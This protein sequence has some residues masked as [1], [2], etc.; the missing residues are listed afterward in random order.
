MTVTSQN[1][2]YSKCIQPSQPVEPVDS[3][4]VEVETYPLNLAVMSRRCRWIPR[5]MHLFLAGEA[6]CNIC[7]VVS[8]SFKVYASS[9]D[10]D[11]QVLG[12]FL[13]GEAL[14]LE[15]ATSQ[16]HMYS[17]VALEDAEVHEISLEKM[18]GKLDSAESHNRN[19]LLQ[20]LCF[21][22]IANNYMAMHG[23]STKFSEQR[24]SSFL[25]GLWDR[26]DATTQASRELSLTMSRQDIGD[27]LGLALGTVSRT[28][29]QLEQRS[30]VK[31]RCRSVQLLDPESLRQLASSERTATTNHV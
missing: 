3:A 29:S 10:G 15:A 7:V 17:A 27:Y 16:F 21:K 23:R 22:T 30:L 1:L 6:F 4:I 2:D 5:G 13:P 12:F 18:D 24:L 14:G 11:E 19:E 9:L 31:V 28:F 20:R 25:L 8:G 26:L